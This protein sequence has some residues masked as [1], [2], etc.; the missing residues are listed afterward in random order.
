[1]PPWH[2]DPKHGEF[3]NDRRLS[4]ADKAH[5]VA[6]A[7][8]GA[9]EG[10]PRICRWRRP[11]TSGWTIGTPDAVFAMNEDYPIPATGEIPYQYF[12][13]ATNSRKT[14]GSRHSR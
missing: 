2:A 12:E 6:R 7:S 1:M 3:L 5:F 13:I 10:K 11:T 4:D 14:S 8:G 9:P